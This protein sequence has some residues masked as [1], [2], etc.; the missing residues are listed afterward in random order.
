MCALPYGAAGIMLE[1]RTAEGLAVN[2]AARANGPC[3]EGQEAACLRLPT[4]HAVWALRK[5]S[6]WLNAICAGQTHLP[7]HLE[8]FG[9]PGTRS[10]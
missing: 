1:T 4:T 3:L 9:Q 7:A 6:R 8:M 2:R 5:M 10:A